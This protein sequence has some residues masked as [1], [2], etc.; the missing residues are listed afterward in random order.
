MVSDIAVY[1]SQQGITALTY[2]T[3]SFGE[4]DGQPRC[5]LDLSK[6]VDDYSDAFTFLASLPSVDPSKIGFWGISFC[7]TVALNAAALDRR[8]R[9]VISVGPIVKASDENPYPIDKVHR[10]LTKALRDRESQLRG[11][12]PFYVESTCEDGSNPTGFGPELGI[13]AYELVQRI[14]AS[15]IA[16]NFSTQLTLQSFAKI[17]RWHP[18]QDI[19]WLGETPMM[20]MIPGDDTVSLPEE[21]M[22]LFDMITGPKRVEVAAGKSHFNVLASEGFEGLMDMQVEFIK[23]T[24][25]LSS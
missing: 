25:G 7:A 19:K 12:T 2:D 5:E 4:S 17:L 20:L 11:N 21:Q 8:S 1:F 16:P 23:Q 22:R 18:M 14:A 15:G 6:Q 13:E 24:L 10:V 3:R 9:F